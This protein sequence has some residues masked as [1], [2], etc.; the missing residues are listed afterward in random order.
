MNFCITEAIASARARWIIAMEIF[1]FSRERTDT[2]ATAS[3]IV[4]RGE[5][6]KRHVGGNDVNE[7]E[8]NLTLLKSFIIFLKRF[9]KF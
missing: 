4:I 5:E 9:G 3:S 7:I 6:V 8:N 1:H 2:A